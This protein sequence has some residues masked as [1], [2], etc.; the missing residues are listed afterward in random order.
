MHIIMHNMVGIC[1]FQQDSFSDVCCYF[2][3]LR[4]GVIYIAK[5]LNFDCY[6]LLEF[7]FLL[8]YN[9]IDL[10]TLKI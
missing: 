9:E 10:T 2:H 4:L 3:H 6:F 5:S 7:Y 8:K 1:Y